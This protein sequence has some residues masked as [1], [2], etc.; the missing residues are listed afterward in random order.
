[1]T[2]LNSEMST[3]SSS[4]P[5]ALEASPQGKGDPSPSRFSS[6]PDIF[7]LAPF[8][9]PGS[10]SYG[11]SYPLDGDRNQTVKVEDL[12]REKKAKKFTTKNHVDVDKSR[13]IRSPSYLALI[14][15][16]PPLSYLLFYC[17]AV[18]LS[19]MKGPSAIRPMINLSN[20]IVGVSILAMP[21]CFKEVPVCSLGNHACTLTYV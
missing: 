8:S 1:M 19:T 2:H 3:S 18:D 11:G 13:A 9:P 6:P 15:A 14:N 7:F 21:Y 12:E 17:A 10:G 20:S 5:A 4:S 16:T